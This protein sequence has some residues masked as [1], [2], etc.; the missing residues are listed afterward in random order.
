MEQNNRTCFSWDDSDSEPEQQSMPLS[1]L[2]LPGE[3]PSAGEPSIKE[4][5]T[6]PKYR[7]LVKS[8]HHTKNFPSV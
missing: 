8:Q 3:P 6:C 1:S 4:A 5:A 7:N 2:S